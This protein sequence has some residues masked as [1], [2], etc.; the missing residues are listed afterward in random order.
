M[1]INDIL[2]LSKIEAQKLEIQPTTF[3]LQDFLAIIAD[4]IQIR[5]EQAGLIFRY[6]PAAKLPK[7]VFGDEKRLRQVLLNLLGNAVKFTEQGHVTLKV[8]YERSMVN[9]NILKV[10]CGRYRHWNTVGASRRNI[11]AFSPGQ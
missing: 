7:A 1:L 4:I 5:T 10:Q 3:L 9:D 8:E 11:H 2:D 6:E